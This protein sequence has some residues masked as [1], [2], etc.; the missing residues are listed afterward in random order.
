MKTAQPQ[1][2]I[3]VAAHNRPDALSAAIASVVHQSRP[4]WRLLVI[5]DACNA[6]TVAVLT[7]FQDERIHFVNLPTWCGEQA[8]PNSVGLN[9][10][11]APY[12]ALL[13]HDDVWMPDHLAL[14]ARHLHNG[15]EFVRMRSAFAGQVTWRDGAV[16]LDFAHVSA[17]NT[18][19][20]SCLRGGSAD[21]EPAS[22]WVFTRSLWQAVGNWHPARTLHRAPIEDWL[23][24][25]WRQRPRTISAPEC[26]V[27][28]IRTY[29]TTAKTDVAYA[30]HSPE[31]LTLLRQVADHSGSLRERLDAC[32]TA[33]PVN[34]P[35]G[36]RALLH[37][38]EKHLYLVWGIDLILVRQRLRGEPRGAYLAHLVFKRTGR[39]L[40]PPPDVA[41]LQRYVDESVRQWK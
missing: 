35:V 1:F 11:S 8:V 13:N 17:L 36:S 20:A 2:D 7:E 40:P 22:S 12:L 15:Y 29:W 25:A 6:Q 10:L 21:F 18:N 14:A 34:A 41:G 16:K 3:V 19:F 30:S 31:Y 38:I 26:T 27:L 28:N 37:R 23:L 33:L 24:R 32:P 39:S 9:A 5:G 4:D